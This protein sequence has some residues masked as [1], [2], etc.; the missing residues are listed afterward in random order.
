MILDKIRQAYPKPS[1]RSELSCLSW[2]YCWNDFKAKSW[3]SLVKE[4]FTFSKVVGVGMLMPRPARAFRTWMAFQSLWLVLQLHLPVLWSRVSTRFQYVL[5][6]HQD[7]PENTHTDLRVTMAVALGSS[8]LGMFL[9][10]RQSPC[11]ATYINQACIVCAML[12]KHLFR[13]SAWSNSVA[14]GLLAQLPSMQWAW[15]RCP[16]EC[17]SSV[18]NG[19]L[20]NRVPLHHPANSTVACQF[21]SQNELQQKTNG[22]IRCAAIGVGSHMKIE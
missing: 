16:R 2:L 14:Y 11:H 12:S 5:L 20:S 6:A 1:F 9:D 4:P 3:Y 19:L 13:R 18:W 21:P 10:Q 17:H 8:C 22:L 7:N 15:L